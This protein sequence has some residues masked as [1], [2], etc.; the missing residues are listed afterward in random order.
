MVMNPVAARGRP[1]D[2]VPSL[3]DVAQD[4][5]RERIT[6]GEFA[7]GD[8]LKERDLV[9]EIGISRVPIREALRGL[10][11]EGFV[12]LN[13]RRGAVV[14]RLE[15]EDL[16][17][18]Y[19]VR[20]ALEALEA[21]LAARKAS[22]DEITLMMSHVE[23]SERAVVEGDRRAADQANVAFHALL[24]QMT[25]NDVL[26]RT[27]EPLQNRLNWLLRQ[28]LDPRQLCVEHR[29]LAEAIA[30]GDADTARRLAISHVATSKQVALQ[31]LFGAR[32]QS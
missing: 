21:V 20:E 19:E 25:H 12:T 27:L 17:E 26:A 1:G 30:A 5:L 2:R 22:P 29:G 24:V 31:Q 3:V 4:Y 28:N 23:A 9:E 7:P 6:S 10:A 16:D 32:G 13:P 8:R 15:P 11:S 14:T 18:I